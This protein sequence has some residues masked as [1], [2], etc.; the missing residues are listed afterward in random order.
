MHE[1]KEFPTHRILT[2]YFDVIIYLYNAIKNHKFISIMAKFSPLFETSGFH[3]H[4]LQREEVMRHVRTS[5]TRVRSRQ[6]ASRE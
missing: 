6:D 2:R 3:Y 4:L 5:S 1:Y